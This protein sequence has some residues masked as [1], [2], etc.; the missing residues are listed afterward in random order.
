LAREEISK[1][2]KAAELAETI[3]EE[4]ERMSR[5]IQNLLE[6]TRFESGSVQLKTELYPLE[7]VLGS[8]LERLEKTLKG[9]TI[10]TSLK[11][12]LPAV[13]MDALLMEQVFINLIENATRHAPSGP[14]DVEAIVEGDWLKVM[15]SDRG[16]GLRS[17]ELERVFEKFYRQESSKGAGLG[18]S[19]C[20][21]VVKAHGGRIWAEN[22]A[23]GGANFCFTLPLEPAR[24]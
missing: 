17:D 1:N 2:P 20:R 15:I 10:M 9:R 4:G 6:A 5:Q 11:E 22:R 7:E 19:I 14:I 12:D 16:P 21:G 3:Q 18:L 23:G 13:R 8:A 24:V